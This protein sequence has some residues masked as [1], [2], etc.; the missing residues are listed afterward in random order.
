M[1]ITF[2]TSTNLTEEVERN[3]YLIAAKIQLSEASSGVHEANNQGAG[4]KWRR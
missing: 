1:R 4:I 3:F 2:T